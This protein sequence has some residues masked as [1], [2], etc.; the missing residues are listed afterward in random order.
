[1]AAI[2]S[3]GEAIL[4]H[5]LN[6]QEVHEIILTNP[7][8]ARASI[9][10]WGA[11]VRDLLVPLKGGTLRRVVLGYADISQY[12][13]NG[14][15]LGT[16]CGRVCNRIAHGRFTL[17]GKD[18]QLPV[19][20]AGDV[21]LHGGPKGFTLRNWEVVEASGDTVLLRIVSP[22]GEE[23]YPGTVT[24]TCRYTLTGDNTLRMEL[25]GASDA[26]TL[27]NMTNH[28]YFTLAE[29]AVAQDH[30]LEVVSDLYTPT[31]PNLIPTGEVLRVDDSRYDFREL[32]RL[33]DN[34]E[35]NFV[36]RG[37]RGAVVP[38][39]RLASPARD[40]EM[41]VAT[42]QPGLLLYTAAGLREGAGTDGQRLGPSL[43]ICLEAAGFC[44]SVNWRHFPSPILRPGETYRNTCEYRFRAL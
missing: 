8:G 12:G 10:S 11:V 34:F 42:D 3:L 44:D 1:M 35:A 39:A 29:G 28:S 25:E 5:R 4:T 20:G 31:R 14:P 43:G 9:L 15:H 16:V 19:N 33:G 30:W 7:A 40:L 24:V 23:G 18:Y 37:A 38:V 36:L 13:E 41:E 22:D 21:H 26:A 32:R 27:L 6:G 2:S 17:D